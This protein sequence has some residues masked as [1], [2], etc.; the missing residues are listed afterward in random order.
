[1]AGD[2]Y[3][4]AIQTARA[5]RRYVRRVASP[6]DWQRIAA[7][8][9]GPCRVCDAPPPN[10]LAHLIPRSQGGPDVEFN[11]APLCRRDHAAFD[12]RDPGTVLMVLAGLTDDEYAGL[13]EH[14]G[15]AVFE[16][17]FN[18]DYRRNT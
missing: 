15:E 1:M 17:H 8:K 4:K 14:A 10:D 18:I 3:P 5:E 13:V 7:E 12:A 6:K 16:R 11:I 2:P 9:Q